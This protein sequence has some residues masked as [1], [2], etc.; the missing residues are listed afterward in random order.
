MPNISMS[1]A[2]S[3][4]S[5]FPFQLYFYLRR[6]LTEPLMLIYLQSLCNFVMAKL[7][8]QQGLCISV[9]RNPAGLKQSKNN[10]TRFIQDRI[11]R[12][13]RESI[14]CSINFHEVMTSE[15]KVTGIVKNILYM[16]F[17]IFYDKMVGGTAL[18][19][20]K[21]C[22]YRECIAYFCDFYPSKRSLWQR[23][24]KSM[25]HCALL[26]NATSCISGSYEGK[27]EFKASK[28]MKC[29]WFTT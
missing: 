16:S 12:I 19:K 15:K 20:K 9:P 29:S 24:M 28:M 4:C 3:P 1:P 21:D 23:P 18:F 14:F 25:Q 6:G 10:K 22:I 5:S 13:W 2:F 11:N 27:A 17:L 8:S 26:L 7:M